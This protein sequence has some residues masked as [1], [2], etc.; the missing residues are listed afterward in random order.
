MNQPI[1][2]GDDLVGHPDWSE[3]SQERLNQFEPAHNRGRTD[4]R[5]FHSEPTGGGDTFL[6]HATQTTALRSDVLRL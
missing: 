3:V 2:K 6:T 5:A 4:H 1:V